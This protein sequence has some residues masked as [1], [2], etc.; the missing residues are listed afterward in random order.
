MKKIFIKS[1][2]WLYNAPIHIR[3]KE[4]QVAAIMK[5]LR[6]YK[7]EHAWT[8]THPCVYIHKRKEIQLAWGGGSIICLLYTSFILNK[9]SYQEL[10]MVSFLGYEAVTHIKTGAEEIF[11]GTTCTS[12]WKHRHKRWFPHWNEMSG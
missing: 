3:G 10:T 11:S 1:L 6:G 4:G 7:E 12:Q 5:L 9:L 8:Y 2:M